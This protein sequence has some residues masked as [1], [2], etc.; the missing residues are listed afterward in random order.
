VIFLHIIT[1]A[2]LKRRTNGGQRMMLRR[3]LR[4]SPRGATQ[5]RFADVLT[6]LILLALLLYAAYA[7]FSVYNRPAS[8]PV[9]TESPTASP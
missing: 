6:A 7:Q 8:P 5:L 9:A 1:A 4:K 2:T 3:L